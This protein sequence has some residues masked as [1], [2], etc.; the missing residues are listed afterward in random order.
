MASSVALSA[1]A[2][3]P[4]KSCA[5]SSKCRFAFS[6]AW[7]AARI[8]GCRSPCA[9]ETGDSVNSSVSITARL[10]ILVFIRSSLESL[11]HLEGV[12]RPVIEIPTKPRARPADKKPYRRLGNDANSVLDRTATLL[13]QGRLLALGEGASVSHNGK[14]YC[15]VPGTPLPL[16]C[17]KSREQ[18]T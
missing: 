1:S 18:T 6:S 13:E 11:V 9:G 7:I 10:M 12:D 14:L 8:S 4:P 2:L 15:L 16:S 17:A 5:A 3:C